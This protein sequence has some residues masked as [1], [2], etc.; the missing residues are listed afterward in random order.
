MPKPNLII[1]L[2][3]AIVSISFVAADLEYK[4]VLG[5]DMKMLIPNN[6]IHITKE[7]Y[8]LHYDGDIAPDDYYCNKDTSESIG[9]L[10]MPKKTNDFVWCRNMVNMAFLSQASKTYFND[11]TTING[12][13]AYVAVF[14]GTDV[15]K[16]KYMT[17]FFINVKEKVVMGGITCD[18][19]LEHEWM[20][21][22]EKI[23][24]S[25]KLN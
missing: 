22:S 15:G 16:L 11:T 20:P 3:L 25:I 5:G 17:M 7:A 8:K 12:N 2:A 23:L 18:I 21:T 9:L 19:K 14:E 4:D 13:K 10:S 24:K 1:V 6:F